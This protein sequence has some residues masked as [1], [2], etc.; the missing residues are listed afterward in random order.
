VP[1][2]SVNKSY[3]STSTFAV[4]AWIQAKF[5]FYRITVM[6]AKRNQF[7]SLQHINA[8]S[9]VTWQGISTARPRHKLTRQLETMQGTLQ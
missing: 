9:T 4:V 3:T 8:A 5:T 1:R 6:Q 7:W 2:L